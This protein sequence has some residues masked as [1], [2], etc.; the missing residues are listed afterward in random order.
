MPA[1]I[2]VTLVGGEDD[3]PLFAESFVTCRDHIGEG[4]D[5]GID[6]LD[7]FTVVVALKTMDMAGIVY[8]TE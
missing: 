2:Y 5:V 1:F 4:L 6:A 7:C 3:K 8:I